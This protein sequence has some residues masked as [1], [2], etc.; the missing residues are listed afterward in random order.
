MK[1]E[2]PLQGARGPIRSLGSPISVTNAPAQPLAR[3]KNLGRA[4]RSISIW[5][6]AGSVALGLDAIPEHLTFSRPFRDSDLSRKL[7]KTG[8][9]AFFTLTVQGAS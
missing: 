6:I 3:L 4:R 8:R 2:S 7:F 5:L 9:N 1:S